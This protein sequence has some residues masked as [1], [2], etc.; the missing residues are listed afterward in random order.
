MSLTALDV[1]RFL[2]WVAEREEG[3]RMSTTQQGGREM[4]L[5]Q[6]ARVLGLSWAQTYRLLLLGRLEARQDHRG[7]WQ[8]AAASV[9]RYQARRE[10]AAPASVG[11]S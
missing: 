4:T 1:R 7:H 5:A 8:V 10:R 3:N 11:A 2:L 9:R 6:A